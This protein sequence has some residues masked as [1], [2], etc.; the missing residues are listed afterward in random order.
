MAADEKT[1]E[2]D[3]LS[4]IVREHEGRISPGES[5][6]IRFLFANESIHSQSAV[7]KEICPES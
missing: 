1:G 7:V 6:Y 3:I 5:L 4:H 2:A